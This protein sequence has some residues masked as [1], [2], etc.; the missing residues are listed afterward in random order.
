M[1]NIYIQEPPTNGKVLLVTSVGEIDIE[2]WSK[3]APRACRNFVQ[4]CMEGYYDGTIFHRAVKEF[5][6]Q[7]GDPTGTGDGGESIYSEPF[8]DEFHSRLRFVRRGLVAM[9]NAGQHDNR[10]QFFFT[11]GM[12][13]ELQGKH[14]IFGK[15]VGDTLYNMLKLQEVET[16]A[17]ERPLYPPKIIRCEIL[18]NPFDDI[19]P[20]VVRKSK[21][22][23]EEERKTK[24][25]SK[26][27]K[28]F[29]L[30]SFGTE[31]EEDEEQVFKASKKFSGKSKSSHDLTNDPKLSSVPVLDSGDSEKS[32]GKRKVQEEDL[33]SK[34]H[35]EAV[36][37]KLKKDE[38][39]PK[40][41]SQK[42]TPQSFDR[43]ISK[44]DLKK[45]KSDEIRKEARKL[46]KEIKASKKRVEAMKQ[47]VAAKQEAV[48][49]EKE[50]P[51]PPK[52]SDP[53]DFLESF[54]QERQ[55]YKKLKK[56]QKGTN[57][58]AETLAMLEKF[59]SK[60]TSVRQLAANYS[61]SDGEG[62]KKADEDVEGAEDDP[63]DLSWMQHRLKFEEPIQSKVL[64]ANVDDAERYEINDP[65]NPLTKRRREEG[66]K[67]SKRK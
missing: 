65:R 45:S 41:E 51:E 3:E 7:G 11:M 40:F 22:E 53:P 48:K 44:E 19:I 34:E 46:Q 28:N 49:E 58:E 2:L 47:G 33:E 8:K 9:A 66:K 57:R 13:P 29:S 61:D 6:V 63:S 10:S 67:K 5:I 21:K 31:A 17:N 30:L 32:P 38:S 36:K 14:T 20:R 25:K 4:L 16:D 23:K 43:E 39:E 56:Q 26:A 42:V 24:S 37:K 12:T 15:V 62:G 27:T 52:S 35:I 1:S 18:S 54:K 64:D 59:Q 50:P 60:L 55:K